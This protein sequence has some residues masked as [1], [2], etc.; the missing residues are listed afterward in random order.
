VDAENVPE[1]HFLREKQEREKKKKKE[2]KKKE[3]KTNE[4]REG[5]LCVVSALLSCTLAGLVGQSAQKK[6]EL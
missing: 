4:R 2:K 1:K 6:R 5:G 3:E